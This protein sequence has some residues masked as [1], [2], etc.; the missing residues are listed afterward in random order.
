MPR[1]GP[2]RPYHKK[3]NAF[4]ADV[5]SDV[6]AIG[7]KTEDERTIRELRAEVDRLKKKP[8]LEENDRKPNLKEEPVDV[9]PTVKQQK[10]KNKEKKEI[11]VRVGLYSDLL[12]CSMVNHRFLIVTELARDPVSRFIYLILL[13]VSIGHGEF[14]RCIGCKLASKDIA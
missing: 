6:E 14:G 11:I 10:G 9:K 5:D 13:S 1:A 8:K 7:Q 3:R 4:G 12:A 2:S